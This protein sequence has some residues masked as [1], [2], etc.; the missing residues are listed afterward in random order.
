MFKNVFEN[1]L[2]VEKYRPK[3]LE[4]YVWSSEEQKNQIF[5]MVKNKKQIPHLLFSGA[6]GIGKTTLARV[7][8]NE[9]KI[10][11]ADILEINGSIENGIDVIR[12]KIINFVSRIGISGMRYV[13]F[14]EADYIS[15]N[16]Q[17]SLRNLME[18]YSSIS[19]I[20]FTCNYQNKIIPAIKS[21]CQIFH[22]KNLDKSEFALRIAYILDSE[23]VEYDEEILLDYVEKTFPD[24]R[25]C[26][27]LVQQNTINNKLREYSVKES[28][29]DNKKYYKQILDLFMNNKIIQA[30]KIISENLIREEFENFYRFLYENIDIYC[31]DDEKRLKS[32][33]VIRDGLVN[34][35]FCADPEINLSGTIA[36][37]VFLLKYDKNI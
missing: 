9:L 17:A 19:R 8:L 23:N 4:D 2:W 16:A 18:T 30:R 11:E 31:N 13:I 24:M 14:D 1:D 10:E 32:L 28:D 26:I 25:R 35:T 5:D 6:P 36:K 12:D 7:L 15:A 3:R 22:F 20:I 33:V 37:L 21:R 27:N 34:H 29:N